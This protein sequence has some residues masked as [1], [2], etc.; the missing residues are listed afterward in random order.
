VNVLLHSTPGVRLMRKTRH[1]NLATALADSLAAFATSDRELAT[2][3]L[4]GRHGG[5]P[6]IR[7]LADDDLAW[8]AL[9]LFHVPCST[10]CSGRAAFPAPSA[11]QWVTAA[12]ALYLGA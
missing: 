4:L 5:R 10:W 8:Q 6:R 11:A 9:L 12:W 3:V 2:G 7:P 1:R